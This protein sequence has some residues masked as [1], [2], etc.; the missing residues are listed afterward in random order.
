MK[1]SV[2]RL[3]R[4]QELSLPGELEREIDEYAEVFGHR[5]PFLWRWVYQTLTE[6]QQSSV[7]SLYAQDALIANTRLVVFVTILDDIVDRSDT[8]TDLF[9]AAR[10]RLS[11]LSFARTSPIETENTTVRNSS[12]MG[13]NETQRE[14]QYIEQ[15]WT[16]LR[17]ALRDAPRFKEF[18]P[19]LEYDIEGA[20]RAIK[21]GDLVT[22]RPERGSYR[23]SIDRESPIMLLQATS[24]IDLMFSPEFDSDEISDVRDATMRS[25]KISRIGNWVTT[26]ERELEEGDYTSGIFTKA[27]DDG[28]VSPFELRQLTETNDT[29]L[30]E[31]IRERIIDAGIAEWVEQDL[32]Q[33]LD[34]ATSQNWSAESVDLEQYF[35]N[36]REMYRLQQIAEGLK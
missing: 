17:D 14:L 5:D 10:R 8:D 20:L 12:E 13:N 3:Q 19:L 29:E 11:S 35:E 26:W 6:I 34:A 22:E 23:M 9:S 15:Q 27:M 33:R 28:V 4:I 36:I 16:R 30:R 24:E 25:Q 1:K 7:S 32:Y 2:S 18:A 31:S 21:Y